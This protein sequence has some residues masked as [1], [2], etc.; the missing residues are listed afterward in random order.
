[1][2]SPTVVA[3]AN[4]HYRL[5]DDSARRALEAVLALDPDLVGLQEWGFTRRRILRRSGSR[6]R[7]WAPV[8]GGCPVGAR[9]DRFE[10]TGRRMVV[11]SRAGRDGRSEHRFRLRR[12]RLATVATYRDRQGDR[13]VTLVAYHLTPGV[14]ALGRYREDR[15]RL[16]ARHRQEVRRLQDLVDGL[17]AR[18]HVVHALGDSNFDGLRLRGLTSAWE[19]R[20]DEPGTLGPRRKV[21]DVLSAPGRAVSVTRLASESDHQAV[22]VEVDPGD[23]LQ[24]DGDR[25]NTT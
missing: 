25:I 12:A 11:L 2:T 1:M 21:D 4:V 19:G 14:Q 23:S 10:L 16:V 15:P 8:F 24:L 17:L 20:A 7:W 22:I 18:G 5:P 6:Y 13:A 9:A 3:T